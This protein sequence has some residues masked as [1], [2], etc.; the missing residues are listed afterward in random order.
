M[1][2]PLIVGIGGTTRPGSSGEKA[3]RA[4]LARA[5][6]TGARTRMFGG[7]ELAA[8]PHFAPEDSSRTPAQRALVEAVRTCD[9]LVIGTP[10]YHGGVSGLV[11]NALDLLEDLRDDSRPY[12]EGRAVGC[13]VT[14]AG[15]QA[16]GVTLTALRGIVHAMRGWPTPLGVTFNTSGGGLFGPDGACT[17]MAAQA[18]LDMLADQV[19]GF[20]RRQAA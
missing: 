7:A 6:R 3:V 11:K 12:F 20:A 10:G 9:G 18:N 13:V 5:E 14:A 15:W 2:A 8:L 19:T 4:A 1:P 16:C 17:D